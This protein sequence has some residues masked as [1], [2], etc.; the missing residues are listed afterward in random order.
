[1][2]RQASGFGQIITNNRRPN[3]KGRLETSLDRS[4]AS[5]KPRGQFDGLD[6]GLRTTAIMESPGTPHTTPFQ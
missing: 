3:F 2:A 5:F 1:M 4:A 6:G